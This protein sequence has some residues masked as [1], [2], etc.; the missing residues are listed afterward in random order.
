MRMYQQVL[1][2]GGGA[3]KTLERVLGCTLQEALATYSG[4]GVCVP[5]G[6]PARKSTSSTR[7]KRAAKNDLRPCRA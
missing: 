4:R 3:I 7:A 2:I 1:D 5:N 6:H